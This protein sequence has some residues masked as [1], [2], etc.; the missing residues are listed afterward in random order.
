MLFYSFV[1]IIAY[2][3]K[4]KNNFKVK[5]VMQQRPATNYFFISGR[6]CK[7]GRE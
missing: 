7:A 1:N 6:Q 5:L 3:K 4:I 2:E